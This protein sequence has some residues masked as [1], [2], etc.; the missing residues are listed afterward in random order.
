MCSTAAKALEV[1]HVVVLL[2]WLMRTFHGKLLLNL[3]EV[4]GILGADGAVW[5][6]DRHFLWS[7]C[8]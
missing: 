3:L 8:R 6:W 2:S 7:V 1:G 5:S 4:V